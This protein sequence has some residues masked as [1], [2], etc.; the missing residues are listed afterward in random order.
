MK[1]IEILTTKRVYQVEDAPYSFGAQ[2]W[3][4]KLKNVIK[5]D[6]ESTEYSRSDIKKYLDA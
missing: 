2:K 3:I 1:K 4:Q 6:R 5:G